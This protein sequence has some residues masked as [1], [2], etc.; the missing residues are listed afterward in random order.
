MALF[1][2]DPQTCN[3]DGLC[4][5]VCPPGVIDFS[6]GA[7]PVP[8]ADAEGCASA[9]ATVWPCARRPVSPIGRWRPP[10]VRRFRPN[11]S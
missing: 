9:A 10:T 1:T 4:A 7:L 2:I 6:P 3:Q 8:T 11:R 5:A